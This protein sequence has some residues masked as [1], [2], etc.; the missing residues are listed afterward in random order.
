MDVIVHAVDTGV[1]CSLPR[2]VDDSG[3]V[4]ERLFLAEKG[5]HRRSPPWYSAPEFRGWNDKRE[6]YP[7]RLSPF[8]VANL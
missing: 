2:I 1:N 5:Q 7:A 4:V 6:A 3:I 8:A